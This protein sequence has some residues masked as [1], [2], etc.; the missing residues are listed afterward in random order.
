MDII[1]HGA[2]GVGVVRDVGAGQLPDEP[3]FHRAEQQVPPVRLFPGAGDVVQHP[4]DLGGGEVGVDQQARGGL[5]ALLQPPALQLLA[6]LRRPAALPDDGVVYRPAG[7][8]VPEDGSL[9]LVGD[10]DAGHLPLQPGCGLGSRTALR[11]PDLHGVML[12]PAGLGIELAEGK[13]GLG[14]NVAPAVKHDGPGAGGPLVQRQNIGS[15]R[16]LLFLFVSEYANIGYYST[17]RT[18]LP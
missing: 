15:H 4:A 2:G 11:L 5:D 6:E 9:P 14:H 7:G 10:A 17:E 3:R 18:G 16:S 12:Y 13:L 1:Q 8:L